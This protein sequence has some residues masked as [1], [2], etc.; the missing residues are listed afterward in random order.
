MEAQ[1]FI[2]VNL[3]LRK[4]LILCLQAKQDCLCTL[5]SS[6]PFLQAK[7]VIKLMYQTTDLADKHTDRRQT[8]NQ[9]PKMN[10]GPKLTWM[11]IL[12]K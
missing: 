2:K 3:K 7:Y 11:R 12:K 6:K 8:T 10:S 9:A 5:T 1:A 4:F